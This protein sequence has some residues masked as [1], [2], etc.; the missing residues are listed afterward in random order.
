[1]IV[2][3]PAQ[4][5]QTLTRLAR[6]LDLPGTAICAAA[7]RHP[8]LLS[9]D[10]EALR[11]RL[12]ANAQQLGVSLAGFIT[13]AL[14]T[15]PLFSLSTANIAEKMPL[16]EALQAATGLKPDMEAALRIAPS[17]LTY[18]AAR[19]E[20]RIAL[21]RAYPGRFSFSVLLSMPQDKA[22]G[23]LDGRG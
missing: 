18:A 5:R 14:K 10:P 19:L 23:L 16:I 15:P 21:A 1:M 4:A 22:Q 3:D 8:A 17:A 13:A 2:L 6:A 9:A 12:A 7:V 20:Q 11:S